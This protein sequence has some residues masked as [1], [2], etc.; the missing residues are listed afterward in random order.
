M[1]GSLCRLFVLSAGSHGFDRNDRMFFYF[2]KFDLGD[3]CGPDE[4]WLSIVDGD[5]TTEPDP[6]PGNSFIVVILCPVGGSLYLLAF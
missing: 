5:L 1:R 4:T 6:I 3:N 2:T